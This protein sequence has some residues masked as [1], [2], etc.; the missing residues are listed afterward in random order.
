MPAVERVKTMTSV[1]NVGSSAQSNGDDSSGGG[2]TNFLQA[3]DKA[4]ESA[5]FSSSSEKTSA[6]GADSNP[7]PQA[8]AGKV[9]KKGKAQGSKAKPAEVESN[10]TTTGK[11]E[12]PI[13][14]VQVVPVEAGSDSADH[15]QAP[16]N[17]NATDSDPKAAADGDAQLAGYAAV[18]SQLDL[19]KQQQPVVK[20]TPAGAMG[21][22]DLHR[23]DPRF[24][25]AIARPVVV[26]DQ[27]QASEAEAPAPT[28][29]EAD[30]Q[31]QA[32]DAQ[33][34]LLDFKG[35]P[36]TQLK[37]PGV[38]DDA[39]EVQAQEKT[40]AQLARP[41]GPVLGRGIEPDTRQQKTETSKGT[42][43]GPVKFSW[44]QA[45]VTSADTNDVQSLVVPDD[46]KGRSKN[47]DDLTKDLAS[48]VVQQSAPVKVEHVPNAAPVE[49]S[50]EGRFAEVNHPEI[51]RVV[52][53]QLLPNGGTLQIR[54]DPPDLGPL[55]VTVTMRDGAMSAAFA[56]A[57]DQATR[58]LSHS[59]GQLKMV[60][61]TA[62]VT[63][64][65]LQVQQ[66]PRSQ[67]GDASDAQQQGRD[68]QQQDASSRQEQQRRE[69]L[70]RMWEKIQMG[71]EDV[72]FV[73]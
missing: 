10:Q 27:V 18:S 59:L 21:R 6:K 69:I 12:E 62:G 46:G 14:D 28:D 5:S 48:P 54:L 33:D 25:R 50:P 4:A 37:E 63:V 44:D 41:A 7:K 3:L 40:P 19:V 53:G 2:Q 65:K 58:L 15:E 30:G 36:E 47:S 49:K 29:E 20:K 16:A 60:L 17:V 42:N 26:K 70:E 32:G 56:T 71:G 34:A 61:E 13:S 52:R 57:N 67:G 22:A 66:A 73:G 43:A 35:D 64:E 55:N 45:I 24:D 1:A 31:P 11:N 39:G 23:F 51:V 38:A 8:V 9:V 72:D 68:S